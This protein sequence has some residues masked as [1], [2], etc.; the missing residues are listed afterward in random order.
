MRSLP[1]PDDDDLDVACSGWAHLGGRRCRR[2]VGQRDAMMMA[3]AEE[4]AAFYVPDD[5]QGWLLPL[6][7]ERATKCLSVIAAWNE[8]RYAATGDTQ[9]LRVWSAADALARLLQA[10]EALDQAAVR[11]RQTLALLELSRGERRTAHRGRGIDRRRTLDDDDQHQR[12]PASATRLVSTLS[13]APGAPQAHT[14]SV[15][16]GMTNL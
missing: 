7:D 6:F 16:A 4:A 2:R 12:C 5:L 10:V 15:W 9:A 13:T 1:S 11:V 8:R 14:R 3:E